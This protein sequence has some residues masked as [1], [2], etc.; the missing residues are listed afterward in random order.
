M[1]F[2]KPICQKEVTRETK[3]KKSFELYKNKNTTYQNLQITVKAENRRRCT[4]LN[5]YIRKGEVSKINNLNL[6]FKKLKKEEKS[7]QVI[8]KE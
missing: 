2:Q 4:A 5:V 7:K 8:G 3:K 1:G 6:R